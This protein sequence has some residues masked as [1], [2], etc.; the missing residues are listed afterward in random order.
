MFGRVHV[1]AYVLVGMYCRNLQVD[2]IFLFIFRSVDAFITLT[3]TY[4]IDFMN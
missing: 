3:G 1:C 4:A 2:M